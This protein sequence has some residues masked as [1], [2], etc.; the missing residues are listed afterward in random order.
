MRLHTEWKCWSNL[1]QLT[2][3]MMNAPVHGCLYLLSDH[4][5]HW[6][7]GWDLDDP[8]NKF[9][10][11]QNFLRLFK[12]TNEQQRGGNDLRND[13]GSFFIHSKLFHCQFVVV[14]DQLYYDNEGMTMMMMMTKRRT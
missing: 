3:T 4:S 10:N 14:L 12:R 11:A 5:F 8:M 9:K 6:L 1:L 13:V 2:S 7:T